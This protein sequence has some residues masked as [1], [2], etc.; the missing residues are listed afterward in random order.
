[1]FFHPKILF[2]VSLL[3]VAPFN[4]YL[5]SEF[6]IS[7]SFRR[8]TDCNLSVSSVYSQITDHE[9]DTLVADIKHAFPNCGYRLMCGHL[10][11]QGYQITQMH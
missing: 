7:L 9:L 8:M 6:L 4:P 2:H 3:F 10:L 5:P 11:N 1:M